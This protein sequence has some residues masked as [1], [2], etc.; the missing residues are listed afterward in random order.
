MPKKHKEN[1]LHVVG[2]FGKNMSLSLSP[3]KKKG[4][5]RRYKQKRVTKIMFSCG[6]VIIM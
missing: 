5:I 3:P 1:I 6:D 4:K 2:N